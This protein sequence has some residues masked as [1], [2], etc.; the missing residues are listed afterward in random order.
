MNIDRLT[1]IS[2]RPIPCPGLRASVYQPKLSEIALLGEREFYSY[3]SVFK[4]TAE[5]ILNTLSGQ[6][7]E[8]VKTQLSFYTDFQTILEMQRKDQRF[9]IGLT[10]ILMML[11]PQ[12]NRI[13]YQERFILMNTSPSDSQAKSKNASLV[14]D[15]KKW[16]MLVEI[17]STI[18]C[19]DYSDSDEDTYNP[20][21][22]EAKRIAEKL[23]KRHSLLNSQKNSNED[24]KDILANLVSCLAVESKM[25][26]EQ[27]LDYTIYQ[28]L[29]QVR[30]YNLQEN[31]NNAI[32]SL[33]AGASKEDVEIVDWRKE[34]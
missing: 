4:I 16:T 22:E 18:F 15:D 8:A 7:L 23:K 29:N 14:I 30:R 3:I 21:S 13:E 17:A 32:S 10:T 34:L 1:L 26:I 33:L 2:G 27:V 6:E 11:L 24:R 28:F 31:Y 9:E 19:L 12:Y 20:A 25:S 5:D